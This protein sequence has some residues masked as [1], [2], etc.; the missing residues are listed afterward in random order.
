VDLARSKRYKKRGGAAARVTLDEALI[1]TSEP[2]R[3]LAALDDA[4]KDLAAFDERKAR[5]KGPRISPPGRRAWR[6][7]P[8]GLRTLPSATGST[9]QKVR[10]TFKATS[11]LREAT[12][13]VR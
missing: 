2:G 12:C 1:V 5:V 9:L 3:D 7:R 4:L 10:V 11:G 8:R 6:S 13:G